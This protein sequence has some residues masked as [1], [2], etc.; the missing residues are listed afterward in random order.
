MDIINGSHTLRAIL[1]SKSKSARA[2]HSRLA[3]EA[4]HDL[5]SK[6]LGG[7]SRGGIHPLPLLTWCHGPSG[8]TLRGAAKAATHHGRALGTRTSRSGA[9]PPTSRSFS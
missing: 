9:P 8:A 3:T 7:I 6:A 5:L 4:C 1:K 2:A